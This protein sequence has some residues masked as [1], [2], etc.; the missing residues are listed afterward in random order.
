MSYKFS[1]AHTQ[2]GAALVVSL[3]LLSVLTILALSASQS[4]RLQERMAGNAR[5]VDVAFQSA[6]AGVRNAEDYITGLTRQTGPCP[7]APCHVFSRGYFPD[8]MANANDTWWATNGWEYGTAAK[9]MAMA[10]ADPIYVIEQTEFVGDDLM[11]SGG[12]PKSG[13]TFFRTLSGAK[14]AT[15]SARVVIQTTFVKR[16]DLF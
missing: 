7:A 2:R 8:D 6:E 9:E 13:L 11:E 10:V 15:D 5:D 1:T 3:L 14:G 4:T 16:L 12:G